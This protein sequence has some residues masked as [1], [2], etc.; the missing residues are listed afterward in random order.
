MKKYY[1]IQDTNTKEYY[2]LSAD[3]DG[4]HFTSKV[5]SAQKHDSQEHAE[6]VLRHSPSWPENPFLERILE[7]KA[8][9]VVEE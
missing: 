4:N 9:Y 1:V 5:E 7:I 2:Q 8:I 3:I 6:S